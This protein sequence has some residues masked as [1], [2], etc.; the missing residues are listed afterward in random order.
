MWL[1]L[2]HVGTVCAGNFSCLALAG[3]PPLKRYAD[4]LVPTL[5]TLLGVAIQRFLL[6]LASPPTPPPPNLQGFTL[7]R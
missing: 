5:L 6:W 4:A 1:S 2:M 7:R 3:E